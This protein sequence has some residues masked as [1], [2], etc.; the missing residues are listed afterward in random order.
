MDR[1]CPSSLMAVPMNLVT[2]MVIQHVEAGRPDE[3]RQEFRAYTLEQ[4][5]A[6]KKIIGPLNKNTVVDW[7]AQVDG[8][9]GMNADDLVALA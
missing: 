8:I 2:T 3:V 7:T 5:R 9:T 1:L 6:M 4:A